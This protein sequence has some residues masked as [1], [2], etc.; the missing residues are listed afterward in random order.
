MSLLNFQVPT[1][2]RILY[3]A[4]LCAVVFSSF[5][6]VGLLPISP[7]YLTTL[8]AVYLAVVV[9][10][11]KNITAKQI[12]VYIVIYIMSMWFIVGAFGTPDRYDYS[13]HFHDAIVFMFFGLYYILID[14]L[15]YQ[16]NKNEIKKIVNWYFVFHLLIFSLELYFRI[17]YG[18]N[19]EFG[20]WIAVA[21]K[22]DPTAFIFYKYKYNSI[23]GGD[24][25]FSALIIF[26]VL[27]VATF[28]WKEKLYKNKNLFW[29]LLFS[30]FLFFTF[31]RA[32]IISFVALFMYILFY[33]KQK[34][35]VK[36]IAVFFILCMSLVV[37]NKILSDVSFLSKIQLFDDLFKY[38][39]TISVS[40]VLFGNGTMSSEHIL[41]FYAH[42]FVALFIIEF[43][44]IFF[45]LFLLSIAVVCIDV[46]KHS[47]YI[48]PFFIGAAISYMSPYIPFVWTA[49]ALIKHIDRLC[50]YKSVKEPM[51]EC[52]NDK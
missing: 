46:G 8:G 50:G 41:S 32:M 4:A 17:Q 23:F 37:L 44:V 31:S 51:I 33:Y 35:F 14:V 6:L 30:A 18:N 5:F 26:S 11:Y 1:K 38:L 3:L 40:Q 21:E 39:K 16:V 2:I 48:L 13:R 49:F 7:I 27:G 20:G 9:H 36:G 47:F 19:T 29:F 42:N 45:F 10:S 15:L 52:T 43:G 22:E 28:L 34:I 25:N 24:S 12:M